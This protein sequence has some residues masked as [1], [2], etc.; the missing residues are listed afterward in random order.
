[1]GN[2]LIVKPKHMTIKEVRKKLKMSQDAFAKE[3]SVSRGA[4]A[5]WECGIY[6][7]SLNLKQIKALTTLLEKANVSIFDLPDTSADRHKRTLT[8]K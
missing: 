8:Y 3:L 5:K 4:V 6:E 7:M 1:M 2:K